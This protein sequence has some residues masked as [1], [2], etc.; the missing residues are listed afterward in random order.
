VPD[1]TITGLGPGW[2][3]QP[4]VA[5]GAIVFCRT[6]HIYKERNRRIDGRLRLRDRAQAIGAF[7][8]EG[9]DV[10]RGAG[11]VY[12]RRAYANGRFKH[13][14]TRLTPLRGA[15]NTGFTYQHARRPGADDSRQRLVDGA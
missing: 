7:G 13:T 12:V 15:S 2:M 8:T 14:K 4:K 11:V 9:R 1:L 3:C 6:R 10:D 5:P